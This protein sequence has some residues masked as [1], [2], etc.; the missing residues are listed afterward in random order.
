MRLAASNLGLPAAGQLDL[1]PALAGLGIGGL[2]VVPDHAWR[3][4]WYGLAAAEVERYRRGAARAGLAVVG[5]GGLFRGRPELNL[6]GDQAEAKRAEAHIVHLSAVC[7]DLG[8][9]TLTLA[10]GRRRGGLAKPRA[11]TRLAAVLERVL[12]RIEAHGTVLCLEP[13]AAA[14]GEFCHTAQECRM[15]ANAIDHPALGLQLNA[16]ALAAN[17]ESGHAVFAAIYGRLDLFVADEP[18]LAPLGSS[19]AVDHPAL[20]RHLAASRYD[21]WLV[22][23]QAAGEAPLAALTAALELYDRV[24]QRPDN[25]SLRQHQARQREEGPSCPTPPSP[26]STPPNACA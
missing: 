2:T 20:R 6:L 9:R 23:E 21:G 16:A 24:Y 26:N 7:R 4:T 11:W 15:L 13:M 8:G 3:D 1:L 14:A 5:L 25:L 18:G 19:G 22:V 17:G 10:A 12:P